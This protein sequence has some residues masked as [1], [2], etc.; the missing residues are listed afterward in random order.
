MPALTPLN[1]GT[2]TLTAIP[3]RGLGFYPSTYGY[4]LPYPYPGSTSYPG[5]DVLPSLSTLS[6]TTLN[7][8]ALSEV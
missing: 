5:G 7:L 3:V 4:L 8:T 6:E 2:E 1:E